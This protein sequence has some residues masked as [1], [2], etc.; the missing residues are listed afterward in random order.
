MLEQ[1]FDRFLKLMSQLELLEEKLLQDVNQKLLIS[2]SPEWNTHAVVWR[3]KADLD[4]MRMDDLY[5][6]LKVYEPEVKGMSSSSSSTQNMD[7]LSS[8]NNN[9]SSTNRA[10]ITAK[11]VNTAQAVNTA[12]RVSI[13]ST[14]IN[15][16]YF[17]H[18]DNLNYMEEMDL[19][20]QMAMLTMRARKFLK[21]KEG[22]LLLMAMRLL[23]LISPKWSATTATRRDILLGS[24]ELQEIKT[25]ST[26]KAQEGAEEGPNYALMAF[27]SSSS[28]LKIVDN[29]KKG[30]GYE[31][32][33]AV[34]PPY[35]ENFMPLIPDLSYIDLD[36]FVIKPVVENYKAKSSEEE[37][38]AVRKN[39]DAPIIEEWVSD[40]E[41]ENVSRPKI[42]K[43]TVRPNI[44][45]I[46]VDLKNIVPKGGLTCLFAKATSDESKL[47]H[48][49]LGHLNFK[50]MNKFVK[51]NLMRGLPS[52]LF[53][54]DQTCVACQKGKQYRASCKPKTKNSISLPLHLLHMDLFGLTCVKS[55]MKKMYCL[56]VTYNYSRF[57][58]VF[59][60]ATQ[61]ETSGILKSFITR[62]ENLVHH[63]VKVIR[64]DNG[65]E[66]KNREMNQ[67]CEIKGI[68]RQ[69]SVAKTPQQNGV[70]EM[71]N[72]TLIEAA[73][74]MIAYFKL[75]TT[76]WAEAVNTACYVQNKVLGVKPHNKTPYEL[77]HGSGPD[78]LFDID[79]LTRII[80]YEPIIADEAVHKEFGDSL[81]RAATTASSLGAEQNNGNIA[82]TQSKA[83]PN[84]SS[85]QGT[86]S[87][88]GPR[89]NTP[90]SDEDRMKLNEL[91]ALCT[92]LQNR[93]LELEKTKTS[94]HNE[95]ASL[96]RRV[97]KLEKRNRSRTH[98]LKRL[99]KVGLTARVESS[100]DKESLGED[101]SKQGRIEAIGVDED[102]TLVNDQDDADKDMFDVNVLGGEE[103]KA[104][105]IEEPVKP[106]KKDQIR[107]D[108]EAAI[109]LQAEFDE[110]ERLVGEKSQKEQ[111]AN[112]AL[113]KTWDDIQ[114]KIAA[115]HQL[116]ERMQAQKE[117]KR[118]NT[119]KDFR[120]EL[121]ERKEK[122][123]GEEL[124]QESA[125]K[126][127]VEDDKETAKIKQLMEII[128][129]KEE[130]AVD[131]IPLAVKS[132]RIVDWKIHKE[133][134]KSYYQIV[135]ANGKSHMY[136]VFSKMLE[137][138]EKED[139]EDLYK[140]IKAKF[141]S[142]R[143]V[144]DLD[145]LL[146]GDLKKMFEA[147]VEDKIWKLQQ[148]YKVLN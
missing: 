60:L 68:L 42:E 94:Q 102:I 111:E 58:W 148:E 104:I 103:G 7:F 105:M 61:D 15:A 36:D 18:I 45:K 21:K 116:A 147:H 124:I 4:T 81:V 59:F 84:E 95:I 6:N 113:I 92:T 19:G 40:N 88:S 30:L 49:R 72:R 64:C 26:K 90:R 10:L 93:V 132:P 70:A 63:K 141:N 74:T 48:R 38:K 122:R 43:K 62:I 79:A 34:P 128:P 85:F 139:L 35:T 52:K 123:A 3:N 127:K 109:R 47:W 129:D 69:F 25:T 55:L 65:T 57:A 23:V 73:R 98:K 101:A 24:A 135:R 133:G 108:K 137:S 11:A 77:F 143:L 82:R 131:A 120:P 14:Q 146:W 13:A 9:T 86:D 66:F 136:M 22:S 8:S 54:N 117:F 78:W 67:F 80:N 5:N 110:E 100:D 121:V 31:N 96:K 97:K 53:E 27:S 99:Y 145:M 46:D 76:F 87:G 142:T 115:N 106:K 17:T 75:P 89:G 56:V 32:Y 130:V 112:I 118:V 125:K 1:T 44:A 71:R 91:M 107:L 51:G 16:A 20:W 138:F 50:T 29:C 119:F 28:D 140:L 114:A 2:L 33:N 37:P 134:K 41:E 144:E 39:D 126:Q 83:T 12:N